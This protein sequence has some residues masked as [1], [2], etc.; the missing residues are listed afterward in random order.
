[1]VAFAIPCSGSAGKPQFVGMMQ[2]LTERFN[3]AESDS[4]E[5]QSVLHA[6]QQQ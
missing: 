6:M 3:T 5:A 2:R 4:T 1:L